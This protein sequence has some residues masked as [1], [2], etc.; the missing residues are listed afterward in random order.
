VRAPVLVGDR[1]VGFSANVG[2]TVNVGG[3]SSLAMVDE[4][5]AVDGA[6][7]TLVWGEQSGG[8][9]KPSVERHVQTTLRATISTRP[10]V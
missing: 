8:S 3:W 10:L 9:A 2:Y 4:A 1:L 5:D 6:E 7:V